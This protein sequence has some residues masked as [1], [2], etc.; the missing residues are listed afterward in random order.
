M[1]ATFAGNRMVALLVSRVEGC[2]GAKVLQAI[3]SQLVVAGLA[4]CCVG[5]LGN[6]RSFRHI[7]ESL[8]LVDSSP[9]YA[10]TI[11]LLVV[12]LVWRRLIEHSAAGG[13]LSTGNSS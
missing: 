11:G 3:E 9:T 6:T 13:L 8:G 10:T 2:A 7:V 5:A 1:A 4:V 12:E